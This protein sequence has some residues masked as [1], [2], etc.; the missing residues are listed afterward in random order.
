MIYH[1]TQLCKILCCGHWLC[2]IISLQVTSPSCG[3]ATRRLTVLLDLA[4]SRLYTRVWASGLEVFGVVGGLVTLVTGVSLA[5]LCELVYFLTVRLWEEGREEDG[6]QQTTFDDNEGDYKSQNGDI[7]SHNGDVK[8]TAV[9]RASA[10]PCYP[11]L[12]GNLEALP[13]QWRPGSA[14]T[15]TKQAWDKDVP[16][17][18]ALDS[19]DMEAPLDKT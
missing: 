11:P 10:P 6:G 4:S 7:K 2:L 16:L 15:I 8:T 19:W 1:K 5:S 13:S 17:P 12:V 14:S 9:M 3:P 18:G